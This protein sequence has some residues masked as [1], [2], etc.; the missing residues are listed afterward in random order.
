MNFDI[1]LIYSDIVYL[2]LALQLNL[3]EYKFILDL[4]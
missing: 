4:T 2:L 3:N 1:D